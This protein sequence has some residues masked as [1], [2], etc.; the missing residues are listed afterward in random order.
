MTAKELGLIIKLNHHNN[1]LAILACLPCLLVFP[2]SLALA[3]V[4]L[5]MLLGANAVKALKVEQG[6]N[7]HDAAKEKLQ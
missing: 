5:G 1:L 7:A 6:H 2:A 3:A 4:A